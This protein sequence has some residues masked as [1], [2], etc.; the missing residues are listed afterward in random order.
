M[1]KSALKREAKKTINELSEEKLKV[2]MDFLG[3][4]KQK[5]EMEATLEVLS[6]RALMAQIVAAEEAIKKE[7]LEEFISWE[8]VKRDV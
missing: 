3:Y 7:R 6:S 1:Q 5:E 8:D 2:A 4:L